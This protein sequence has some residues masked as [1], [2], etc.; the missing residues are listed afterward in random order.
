MQIVEVLRK[1]CSFKR[2]HFGQLYDLHLQ[3]LQFLLRKWLCLPLL[4][5]F[6]NYLHT[7]NRYGV[8]HQGRRKVKI[9]ERAS[10]LRPL[11]AYSMLS[12]STTLMNLRNLGG[13]GLPSS[14]P[15]SGDPVHCVHR[16][17]KGHF[18]WLGICIQIHSCTA[19]LINFVQIILSYKQVPFKD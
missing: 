11:A 16:G 8:L 7:S 2:Y 9:F 17:Q 4:C 3:I 18:H 15:S 14:L 1:Y 13:G 10:A 12:L 6:H 5:T 19:R